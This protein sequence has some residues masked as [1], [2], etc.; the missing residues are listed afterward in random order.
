MYNLFLIDM[1]TECNSH[2]TMAT[3]LPIGYHTK[4]T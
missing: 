4:Q 3:K 2:V 1:C